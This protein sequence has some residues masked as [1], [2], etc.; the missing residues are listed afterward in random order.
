MWEGDAACVGEM[1][2]LTGRDH[3]GDLCIDGKIIWILKKWGVSVWSG[4]NYL[5]KGSSCKLI[6]EHGNDPSGS[7]KGEKFLD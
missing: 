5:R 2:N 4:L 7:V 1:E 6:C 3:L